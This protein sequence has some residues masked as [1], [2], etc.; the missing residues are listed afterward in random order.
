[1]PGE[2]DLGRMLARLDPWLDPTP[3]VWATVPAGAPVPDVAAFA[4]I[5]ED[6]G[7]TLVLDAA[8]AARLGLETSTPSRRIVLRVHSALEA[9]GLT[10]AFATALAEAGVPANVVAGFHHDHLLVPEDLA[11][12][13]MEVLAR[14]Q[15]RHRR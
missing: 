10:A 9:V 8:D 11:G 5:A 12:R 2:T 1:M 3:L 7:T 13:A 4:R 6:E 15:A 14:L